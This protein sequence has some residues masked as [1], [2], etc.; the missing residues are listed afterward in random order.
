MSDPCRLDVEVFRSLPQWLC[1]NS[2][3]VRQAQEDIQHILL[4]AIFFD[5]DTR[6]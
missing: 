1:F 3:L 4:K 6:R 2:F 5:L